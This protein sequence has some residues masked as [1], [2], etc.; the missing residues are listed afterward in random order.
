MIFDPKAEPDFAWLAADRQL[1]SL[2]T[3]AARREMVWGVQRFES[4]Q[5]L[6]TLDV[7]R[8]VTAS[9]RAGFPSL[10]FERAR[11]EREVWLWLDTHLRSQSA[12]KLAEEMMRELSRAGLQVRR[13]RFAAV[14]WQITFDTGETAQALDLETPARQA[15]VAVFTDGEGLVRALEAP[16]R[17]SAPRLQVLLR[18]LRTWPRLCLVDFSGPEID[19]PGIARRLGLPCVG[20]AALPRWLAERPLDGTEEGPLAE[21]STFDRRLWAAAC[22]LPYRPVTTAQAWALY[23][24][25]G[26]PAA[27][28]PPAPA[29]GRLH[30]TGIVFSE[31]ER[32][33]LLRD[34]AAWACEDAAIRE[35]LKRALE[36]WEKR[37][38]RADEQMH[39]YESTSLLDSPWADGL[40]EHALHIERRLLKLWHGGERA[41]RAA[42]ELFD[43][44]QQKPL[45][46]PIR[47]R[48]S[49]LTAHG[50]A[51]GAEQAG[52][53]RIVLPWR[54]QALPEVD[55][56]PPGTAWQRL[57]R[58][59]F[60]GARPTGAKTG[61]ETRVV[62]G[63]L[64]GIALAGLLTLGQHVLVPA[65]PSIYHDAAIFETPAFEA[66]VFEN[67]HGGRCYAASRKVAA[68][69]PARAGEDLGVH[70]C[71]TGLERDQAPAACKPLYANE[72]DPRRANVLQRS[73]SGLLRAGSLPEPLRA[74][75]EDWPALSVAV[76]E[77][78]S[79]RDADA[80]DSPR[81]REARRLALQLLDSG[82]VDLALIG[83]DWADQARK[84]AAEWGFVPESQWLFFLPAGGAP[85]W[86]VPAL[87]THR[88]VIAS[89]YG[90]LA[91]HLRHQIDGAVPV[92]ELGLAGTHIRR[93]AGMPRLWG[94]PEVQTVPLP[95]GIEMDFVHVCP[96]TFTMGAGAQ[97]ADPNADEK[98]AHAVLM[99]GFW[100]ARTETTRAQLG[101][102]H[103][104]A[105]ARQGDGAVN[106][107]AADVNWNEAREACRAIPGGGDLPTEAQW[108]Y[109]ARGG[110]RTP[111][112]WGADEARAADYA[113][114]YENAGSKAHS[115]GTRLANP[116]SLFDLHGNVWEWVLDCFDDKAYA[117]RAQGLTADPTEDASGCWRRVVRGGS[118]VNVPGDLRSANRH[119]NVPVARGAA[120]GF[121]CVR[122]SARSR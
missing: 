73:K 3:A 18:E 25:L 1:P 5:W 28:E 50:L 48:L 90:A 11:Y 89:D 15:L 94:G 31:T 98:P 99:A 103:P 67:V 86:P 62:L 77:A 114:Y 65:E 95:G 69:W 20:P 7:A 93:L 27:W 37:L 91:K 92:S 107:P 64:A 120:G 14:P 97:D 22:A 41:A 100:L 88:A 72:T 32:H 71:W 40:G 82:A 30:P 17:D 9:A 113:W 38:G 116:L 46:Q 83:P 33:R 108:E 12:L 34:L 10:R 55:G 60:A 102:L 74:C 119:R 26:L 85:D 101:A 59:G 78:E 44:W 24:A 121:R 110:S 8:T 75:A 63:L 57:L 49:A 70:W 79:W 47:E 105:A 84:L 66:Q 96:G 16:D 68:A 36:F 104:A 6:P 115:M 87:G 61:A 13:G 53:G 23:R 109:A 81:H 52:G 45:Q 54:W 56:E 58:M 112:S 51:R 21:G 117:N 29:A 80:R 4:E 35:Q 118:F 2:L 19:L 39:A 76:I 111:W 43:Q 106:L 42:R 122:G